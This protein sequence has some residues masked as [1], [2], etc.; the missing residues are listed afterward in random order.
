MKR[1][2]K[3]F[4]MKNKYVIVFK[5]KDGMIHATKDLETYDSY[6]LYKNEYLNIHRYYKPYLVERLK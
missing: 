5:S 4:L 6:Q 2:L 3:N 1:N